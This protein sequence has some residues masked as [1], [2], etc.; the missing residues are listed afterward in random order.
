[1]LFRSAKYPYQ[2]PISDCP[3]N[4]KSVHSA[5]FWPHLIGIDGYLVNVGLLLVLRKNTKTS[6]NQ[7]HWKQFEAGKDRMDV[8]TAMEMHRKAIMFKIP[9]QMKE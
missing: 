6:R 7:F 8:A 4:I 1:M 2:N 9:F 3:Q 5:E